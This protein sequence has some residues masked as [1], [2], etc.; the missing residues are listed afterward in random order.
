MDSLPFST[1]RLI[2]P[3]RQVLAVTPSLKA[4]SLPISLD[5]TA[6]YVSIGK[7]V[8]TNVKDVNV[9]GMYK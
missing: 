3:S 7:E 1:G 8:I 9:F 6:Q 2:S 4:K 5:S